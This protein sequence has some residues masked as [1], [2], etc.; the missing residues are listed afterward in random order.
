M[1]NIVYYTLFLVISVTISGQH[2]DDPTFGGDTY[3]VVIQNVLLDGVQISV[4]DE[5]A[6][7]DNGPDG[8]GLIASSVYNGTF[9]M[10]I[11]TYLETDLGTILL[12]GAIPG[13]DITIVVWIQSLDLEIEAVVTWGSG[14]TYGAG[15]GSNALLVEVFSLLAPS[16]AQATADQ[17]GEV[18]LVWSDNS[19]NE[20]GFIIEREDVVKRAF[21]EIGT[22][23]ADVEEFIDTEVDQVATYKYRVKAFNEFSES[24][25]SNET[26]VTTLFFPLNAPT[27]LSAVNVS[28][29]VVLNW[30]D[31][32]LYESFYLI[33]RK[34]DFNDFTIIGDV[35]SD[36][37]SFE[38]HT[39]APSTTYYY[40]VKATNEFTQSEYSEI[41]EIDTPVPV[42]LESFQAEI[43]EEG[44]LLKWRTITE[45]NNMGFEIFRDNEF[46]KFF[47]GKGTTSERQEY[48][49]LDLE[50][51]NKVNRYLLYQLDYDGTRSEVGSI[52]VEVN[53]V[54]KEYSL[55]QNYPNPF[56]PSTTIELGLP[57][58]S[59]VEIVIYNLTGEKIKEVVNENF[60]EGIYKINVDLSDYPS[61]LYLYRMK[62][63]D[64]VDTK[65]MMLLK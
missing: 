48:S 39:V 53:Y 58:A 17:P 9:P 52:E 33:E 55:S 23:G 21:V 63:N 44:I 36:E 38:D 31:T 25:Y 42:E 57:K 54:P 30:D 5:V 10:V 4:G 28:D 61:G 35:P 14:G 15:F 7:F 29:Y 37:T 34:D 12:P 32:N 6:A 19:S 59:N 40:R 8:L 13:N 2:F 47:P 3:P 46:V 24:E 45:T 22:T 20:D 51:E 49:F 26:E 62:T 11:T 16:D 56:N 64:F 43:L 41:V 1:K 65:K 50:K 18:T 27:G 60:R